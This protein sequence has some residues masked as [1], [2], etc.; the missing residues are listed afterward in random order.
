MGTAIPIIGT[1]TT[2]TIVGTS[3]VDG[4]IIDIPSL[5]LAALVCEA[6]KACLGPDPGS[7][8][9]ANRVRARRFSRHLSALLLVA[10]L[11]VASTWT[12]ALAQENQHRVALVIGNATYVHVERLANSGNDAKLIADTLRHLGFTVVGGDAQL[13]LDKTRFEQLVQDFGRQIQGADVALFYYAGHGVQVQGKNWLLPV[14]ANPVRPQDVDFQM[15]DAD[16]VLKQMDGAGTRLN[17][18]I[19][20][21]CRNNPFASLGTRGVAGG[22]AE[23][24]APEGTLISFATQPGNVAADG[25]GPDGPFAVA[26]ADAMHQPGLDIFRL[27]N[28]VGLKVKRDTQGAQQPWVSSSP[29]DG[30][31]FFT[32]TEAASDAPVTTALETPSLQEPAGTPAV[33]LPSLRSLADQGQPKAQ[34]DLGLLLAKGTGVPKDYGAAVPLLEHAAAQGYARAQYFTGVMYE[35]GYGVT[36]DYNAALDW[37]RRAGE[38]NYAPAQ[39]AV[40]RFYGVGIT[41]P[42]DPAERNKWLLR[43]AALGSPLAQNTLGNIYRRGDGVP[44]DMTAAA[45]WYRR[46]AK[47][48]S[49][50]AEVQLAFMYQHGAGVPQDLTTA[51]QLLRQAAAKHNAIAQNAIGT[52]YEHGWAVPQDYV[53]ARTWYELAAAQGNAADEFYLGRL[54]EMGHGVPRDRAEAHK[55][56]E[57]AAAKGNP[58]AIARLARQ[59]PGNAAP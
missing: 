56:F 30:D 9:K 28:N 21:A 7:V 13:D 50:M 53:Q 10:G 32:P 58:L 25:S 31:F 23:M 20:D 14:D 43:A 26:L 35:R 59:G 46:G 49:P 5:L 44:V 22:L 11:L 1:T 4:T 40:A 34:T 2:T 45:Q 57:Q 51:L 47:H 33:P 19:L 42:R 17:I 52:F 27:F 29:I 41:V 8:R 39:I 36:R 54:Y 18:V 12:C 55:W 48:G 37:Y 24:R 6:G 16:L 15:I 38:Q 3:T